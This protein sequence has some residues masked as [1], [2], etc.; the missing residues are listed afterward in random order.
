MRPGKKQ[1]GSGHD[2]VFSPGFMIPGPPVLLGNDSA[3]SISGERRSD[4]DP[5]RFPVGRDLGAATDFRNPSKLT[6]AP[7]SLVVAQLCVD[8]IPK[9]A[10]STLYS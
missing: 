7:E 9:L 1:I 3:R 10:I 2:F 6:I 4:V 5:H 8:Y